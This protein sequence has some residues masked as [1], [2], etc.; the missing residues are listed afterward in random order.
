MSSARRFLSA[1]ATLVALP[2]I[3]SAQLVGSTVGVEYRFPNVGALYTSHGPAVV[4]AGI[5]FTNVAGY[6]QVDVSNNLVEAK[7]FFTS[8]TWTSP[9]GFNGWR[10]FDVG[11]TAPAFTSVTIDPSTN[12]VGFDASRITYDADN[13]YVDWQGLSFTEHTVVALNINSTTAP[14]PATIALTGLGLAGLGVVARRR[15]TA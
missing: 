13:I 15:R 1:L 12:M 9:V 4:G 2:T 5:E 10:F 11:N 7:N 6:F 3:A 14:E 8:A